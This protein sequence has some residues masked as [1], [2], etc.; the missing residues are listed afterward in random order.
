VELLCLCDKS[1]G[2]L[3]RHIRFCPD[4]VSLLRYDWAAIGFAGVEYIGEYNPIV[5]NALTWCAVRVS[6]PGPAD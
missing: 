5:Q 1:V 4:V 2:R 6:N 3:N